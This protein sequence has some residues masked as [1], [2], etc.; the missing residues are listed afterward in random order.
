MAD[1][2]I[3][4]VAYLFFRLSP[5]I[6]VSFFTLQSVFNQDLKGLIYLIGLVTGCFCT[7]VLGKTFRPYE[8][9]PGEVATTTDGATGDKN[10]DLKA[11]KI[12][13][14]MAK[15][16]M[17]TL[18]KDGPVSNLPLSQSVLGF[19]LAYLSFFIGVNNLADS[20]IPTFI[21]LSL[22]ILADFAWNIQ[23]SC[24]DAKYLVVAL[25]I[26]GSV[27]SIWAL[28]IQSLKMPDLQYITGISSAETCSMPSNTVIRCR[29]IVTTE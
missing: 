1:F 25:I 9:I 3:T 21:V 4:N 14:N 2:T 15:C 6:I 22:M 11:I 8:Y 10:T 18:G 12:A 26:G 5:F 23:N 29:P 27:G 7:I 16:N 28:I 17:L 20:N 13:Q 19:T 24:S